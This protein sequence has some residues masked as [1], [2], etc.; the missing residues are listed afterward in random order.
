MLS[1]KDILEI[2]E[3][4]EKAQNPIFFYDNDADGFCS[5]ILLRK[6]IGRGK[7]VVVRSYPDL[8]E[9]YARKVQELKGDYVFVLDKA[10]ISKEFVETIDKINVP[11]VWI[12]HHNQ[13]EDNY[14]KEFSSFYCYNPNRNKKEIKSD[15]PTSYLAYK[16]ANR[17]EDLWIAL[18]GCIADHHMPDFADEFA[19]HYPELW[20]KVK[21]PFDA[22]YG[23]EIG[24]IA[25]A[26][27]FGLKDSITHVVQLQ[28]YMIQC[29]G[30]GD[31][32]QEVI[33]NQAFRNK[34]SEAKKKFDSLISK[35]KKFS[36][37]KVL[38]FVYSGELSMSADVSNYLCYLYPDKYIIVAFSNGA[39]TNIS[40][41]GKDIKKIFDKVLKNFS[42]SHGGGHDDAIGARLK[43][44]DLEKFKEEFENEIK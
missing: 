36:K 9:N 21:E 39:T 22:L 6:Y 20:G 17:K 10:L 37:G 7:G 23:T 43:T 16:I 4:L 26:L 30:P 2:R 15:L 19:E 27:S 33:G 24:T 11:I 40:A 18:M 12:D 14:E 31:V 41:R 25:R 38:F 1:E 29:N 3:H 8:Q 13:S 34:Y 35:A 32:F 42:G 5:F 44:E 28:N